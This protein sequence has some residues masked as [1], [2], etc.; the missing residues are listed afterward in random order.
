MSSFFRADDFGEAFFQ[1]HHRTRRVIH[2]QRGLRD[3]RQ[4]HFITDL[5]ARHIIRA[6]EE[7]VLELAGEGQTLIYTY[8]DQLD[9]TGIAELLRRL[10][11]QGIDFRELQS[12]QSSLEDIFVSLVQGRP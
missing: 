8:D 10:A 11:A 1:R 4:V 7:K 5:E 2:R 3:I 6:F 12:S 9:D